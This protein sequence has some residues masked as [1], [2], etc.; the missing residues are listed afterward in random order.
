M[1]LSV[2]SGIFTLAVLVGRKITGF[3]VIYRFIIFYGTITAVVC[4]DT[5]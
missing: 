3:L 4:V 2:N 5:L 1:K